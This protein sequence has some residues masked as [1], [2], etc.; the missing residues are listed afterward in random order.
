M[1]VEPIPGSEG[2][3]EIQD[4]QVLI[5]VVSHLY[6][7]MSVTLTHS[8]EHVVVPPH[9]VWLPVLRTLF[10]RVAPSLGLCCVLVCE[11]HFNCSCVTLCTVIHTCAFES[12]MDGRVTRRYNR[13]TSPRP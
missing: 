13:N 7:G 12:T 5:L 9:C 6:P 3:V 1:L 10:A 11:E 8:R 2:V 4:M